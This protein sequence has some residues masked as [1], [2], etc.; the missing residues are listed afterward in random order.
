MNA[1]EMRYQIEETAHAARLAGQSV[2]IDTGLPYVD[3][4]LGPDAEYFFQE[5]EAD[6]LL[7][8]AEIAAE[9]FGVRT[10]DVLLWQAQGW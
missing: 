9:K 8:D 7:R 2:T 6:E 3:V 5:S 1:A 10:E 4:C